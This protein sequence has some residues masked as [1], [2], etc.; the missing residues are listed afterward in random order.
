[1]KKGKKWLMYFAA[2]VLLTVVI[3]ITAGASGSASGNSASGNAP[4]P[5]KPNVVQM[6]TGI[7]LN[8]TVPTYFYADTVK[9]VIILS[10]D[11]MVKTAAGLTDAQIKNGAGLYFSVTEGKTGPQA[12]Q[13]VFLTAAMNGRNVIS[14]LDVQLTSNAGGKTNIISRTLAPVVL[15]IGVPDQFQAWNNFQVIS[16][17]NGSIEVLPDLDVDPRTVTVATS[18]FGVLALVY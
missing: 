12:R 13:A 5:T 3:P 10:P 8:S 14:M 2:A 17:A 7:K 1:M 4:A 9:G 16:I 15:T 6:S 11:G 18:N